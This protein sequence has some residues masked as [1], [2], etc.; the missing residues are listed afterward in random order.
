MSAD[1]NR[2]DKINT[3]NNIPNTCTLYVC[4]LSLSTL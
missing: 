3:T 1:L 4:E 2:L